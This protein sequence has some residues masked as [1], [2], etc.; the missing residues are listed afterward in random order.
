MKSDLIFKVVLIL[1]TINHVLHGF[2][3]YQSGLIF[4]VVIWRGSTVTETLDTREPKLITR[5]FGVCVYFV[6]YWF[7]RVLCLSLHYAT[8]CITMMMVQQK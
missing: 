1:R 2:G 8:C 5:V 4:D 3:A 7:S 6:H